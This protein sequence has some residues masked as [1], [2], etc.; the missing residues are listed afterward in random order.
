MWLTR[1]ATYFDNVSLAG[2]PKAY[3]LGI[4]T[5]DGTFSR[6][7]GLSAPIANIPAD[8]WSLPLTGLVTFPTGGIYHLQT[9]ADDGTRIWIDDNLVLD[10]WKN[11][12]SHWSPDGNVTATAGRH[13]ASGWSTSIPLPQPAPGCTGR[14]QP[15]VARGSGE[16]IPMSSLRPGH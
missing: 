13:P 2:T 11:A 14:G 8:G 7:W 4:G 1:P 12:A 9:Q 16:L 15:G 10:D 6:D 5:A 3:G